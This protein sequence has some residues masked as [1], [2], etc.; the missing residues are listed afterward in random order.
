MSILG[1]W[2][3]TVLQ[4]HGT[5]FV[6]AVV[7][8][9]LG[10]IVARAVAGA[11][12]RA[13]NTARLDATLSSFLGSLSYAAMLIL[14]VISALHSLGFPTVSFAA[15]VG[16]A[17]LAIGLA[18]KGTLS[19]FASG[20]ILIALR[21]FKIGDRIEVAGVTGLSNRFRFSP[22][23]SRTTTAEGSSFPMRKSPTT[24]LS[25]SPVRHRK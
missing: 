23:R 22:R 9:I 12:R 14:V 4:Q 18:L 10:W 25:I 8:L 5:R 21:P 17:G 24:R 13:L 2:I 6:T 11:F 20:V 19:N 1:E 16:G 3:R 7:I 15:V